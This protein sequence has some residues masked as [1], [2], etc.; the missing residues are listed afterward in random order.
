MNVAGSASQFFTDDLR[1]GG[2]GALAAFHEGAEQ[3]HAA[4][5][6]NLQE[7]RHSGAAFSRRR[8]GSLHP[9]RA[10]R[11]AETD[12]QRA[13]GR[14]GEEV[15]AGQVNRLVQGEAG[16]ESGSIHQAVL[17]PGGQVVHG[18]MDGV[19]GTAAAQVDHRRVDLLFG[20]RGG[21]L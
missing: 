10:E 2:V 19:V 4:V 12:D 1:H 16:D 9:G 21:V 20:G 15:S 7:G 18:G 5:R 3:A 13:H 11:Q 17:L 14:T 8:G 6:A